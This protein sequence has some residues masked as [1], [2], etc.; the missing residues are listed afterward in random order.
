MGGVTVGTNPGNSAPLWDRT[1]I[2][3]FSFATGVQNAVD[4]G[5][6]PLQASAGAH[7]NAGVSGTTHGYSI[8]GTYS[9]NV[10]NHQYPRE[11]IEKFSYA[12]NV[13]A[14]D[15]GDL[16]QAGTANPTGNNWGM[17]G[18]SGHQV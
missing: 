12:A 6:L 5:D 1:N 15:V 10:H 11:Q 13:T 8:G 16:Q 17:T 4:H 9:W 7:S 14:T 3:K 2:D 18:S